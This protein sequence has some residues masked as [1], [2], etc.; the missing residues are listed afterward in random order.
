MVHCTIARAMIFQS[1]VLLDR[2]F[3]YAWIAWAASWFLAAF[4]RSRAIDRPSIGA[5]LPYRLLNIAGALLLIGV[6]PHHADRLWECTAAVDW[7]L[8]ALTIAGF[9]FC[10]WARLHLGRLWSGT[11][12]RKS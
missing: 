6:W 8:F 9:L 2:L 10:W 1:S 11:V 7:M 4:W 12:T 3:G 5:Q